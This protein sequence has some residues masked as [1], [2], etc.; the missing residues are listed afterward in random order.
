MVLRSS[1]NSSGVATPGR[2]IFS[3]T[4]VP[5]L[6]R[7]SLDASSFVQPF[8]CRPPISTIRSPGCNPAR[9]AGLFFSEAILLALVGKG[10]GRQEAYVLVQ[11][12]AMKALEGE[13]TFRENLE[14]DVEI[15]RLL[16]AGDIAHAFD[17]EHALR[18]AEEI[19]ARARG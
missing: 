7:K 9:S 5:D 14:R 10:L 4:S 19:V 17:L 3:D 6:P 18:Y 8:V 13:G 2:S 11:R 12:N 1:L 15:T 16:S